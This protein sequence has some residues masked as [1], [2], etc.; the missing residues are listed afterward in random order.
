MTP[1]GQVAPGLLKLLNRMRELAEEMTKAVGYNSGFNAALEPADADVSNLRL[2]DN[3]EEYS[4]VCETPENAPLYDIWERGQLLHIGFDVE[5]AAH[6]MLN[7]YQEAKLRRV[8][9]RH[10]ELNHFV[11][12]LRARIE[13][14]E[15]ALKGE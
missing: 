9:A 15:R 2:V 6:F 12:A 11:K 3:G 5:Q 8:T 1:E 4:C 10:A 13:N 7:A 14:V